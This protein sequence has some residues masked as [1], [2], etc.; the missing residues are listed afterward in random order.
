[1]KIAALMIASAEARPTQT[2]GR[3]RYY[4]SL[5]RRTH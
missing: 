5:P 1:M 2:R 4:A 3:G